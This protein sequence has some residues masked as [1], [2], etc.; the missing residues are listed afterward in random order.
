MTSTDTCENSPC[1]WADSRS[2]TA[3]VARSTLP[4][5]EWRID[6]LE[7]KEAKWLKHP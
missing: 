6:S 4:L 2:G 3:T 7:A 1:K 5:A